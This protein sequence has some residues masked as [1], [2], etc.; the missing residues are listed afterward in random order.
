MNGALTE[1]EIAALTETFPELSWIKPED[2]QSVAASAGWRD[3]LDELLWREEPQHA[4]EAGILGRLLKHRQHRRVIRYDCL[5][6]WGPEN[7]DNI[8]DPGDPTWTTEL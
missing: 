1:R 4:D 6:H 2:W 7:V 8:N 5:Q 3:W